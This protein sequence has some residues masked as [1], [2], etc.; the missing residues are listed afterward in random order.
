MNKA[1]LAVPVLLLPLILSGCE[2][3]SDIGKPT[4]PDIPSTVSLSGELSYGG[5]KAVADF[6]RNDGKWNITYTSPESINGMTIITE[7]GNR[8]VS[9][10]GVNFEY[11]ANDVPFITAADYI[12]SCIDSTDEKDGLTAKKDKDGIKLS[13]TSEELKSGYVITLSD[14]GAIT[15]ISVGGAE[16]SVNAPQNEKQ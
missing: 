11:S 13:G 9:M 16:F 8:K 2:A 6:T 7:K 14:D 1:K 10:N 15:H 5:I 12:C 4:V 3:V